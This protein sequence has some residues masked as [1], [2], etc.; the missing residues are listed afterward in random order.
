MIEEG[1]ATYSVGQLTW[2]ELRAH[3]SK[4]DAVIGVWSRDALRM[5]TETLMEE[6]HKSGIEIVEQESKRY[7]FNHME[8]RM[9]SHEEMVENKLS[10][11]LRKKNGYTVTKHEARLH[12]RYLERM[13][14]RT[15]YIIKEEDFDAA[16][17][18]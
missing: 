10:E 2:A 9:I 14:H 13:R 3:L 5:R 17:S 12:V 8:L 11:F 4:I 7:Y 15:G 16:V 1:H 18:S 6:M